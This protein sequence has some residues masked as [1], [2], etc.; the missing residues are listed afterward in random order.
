MSEIV[1]P[2]CKRSRDPKFIDCP[3]CDKQYNFVKESNNLK[4]AD[5]KAA[6]SGNYDFY[7]NPFFK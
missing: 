2:I 1:C 4:V 6:K 5:G 3:F 7:N